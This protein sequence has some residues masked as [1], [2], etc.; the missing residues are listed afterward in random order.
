MSGYSAFSRYY[1]VLTENIDYMARAEYFE[2]IIRRFGGK[3]DGILL[4]LA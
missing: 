4:D 3:K 1:D 2:K